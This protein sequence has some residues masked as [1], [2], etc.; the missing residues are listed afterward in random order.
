MNNLGLNKKQKVLLL[1]LGL[2]IVA[3]AGLYILTHRAPKN[4][5][6]AVNTTQLQ[7]SETPSGLP[8]TLPMDL[9]SKV[10]QNYESVASDGRKQ[11]TKQITSTKAPK[12]ALDSYVAFFKNLGY[13]GGYAES[14]SMANG[15]QVA[16]MQRDQ[17]LLMIVATPISDKLTN[18]EFTMTQPNQ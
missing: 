10:L 15:Q 8:K 7:K 17:D 5:P 4:R 11:S 6:F 16:Q 9:G 13:I 3:G 12:D 2:V 1:G 18:V 14:A